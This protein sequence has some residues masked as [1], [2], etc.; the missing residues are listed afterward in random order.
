[1]KERKEKSKVRTQ[2]WGGSLT[3]STGSRFRNHRDYQVSSRKSFICL[4][5]FQ[6]G[7]LE[8]NLNLSV[9]WDLEYSS[10]Q[11]FSNGG[12]K[13]IKGLWNQ[14]G[15]F[16]QALVFQRNRIDWTTQNICYLKNVRLK[17][18]KLCFCE[19]NVCLCE[20]YLLDC[21]E[22]YLSPDGLLSKN[23]PW[24]ESNLLPAVEQLCQILFRLCLSKGQF[25]YVHLAK[26]GKCMTDISYCF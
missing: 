25:S 16:W 4:K 21:D 19:Y 14:F 6:G 1:M 17:I 24:H 26:Q 7:H 13:P 10:T 23:K 2:V 20:G 12:S 18:I 11:C 8:I 5:L 15:W 3:H 22:K 9:G